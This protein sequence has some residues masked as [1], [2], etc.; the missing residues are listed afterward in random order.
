MAT[1]TLSHHF[2]VAERYQVDPVFQQLIRHAPPFSMGCIRYTQGFVP[3]FRWDHTYFYALKV[4]PIVVDDVYEVVPREMSPSDEGTLA[5]SR[6]PYVKETIVV[7]AVANPICLPAIPELA[8][9]EPFFELDRS[10]IRKEHVVRRYG[11]A[12]RLQYVLLAEVLA[13]SSGDSAASGQSQDSEEQDKSED[14][15]KQFM[16]LYLTR[17]LQEFDCIG[18]LDGKRMI[19]KTRQVTD[20]PRVSHLVHLLNA[21]IGCQTGGAITVA[22]EDGKKS[23]ATRTHFPILCE[24]KRLLHRKS[25]EALAAQVAAELIANA[26]YARAQKSHS[27][28]EVFGILVHHRHAQ[29]VSAA[30]FPGYLEKLDA[31]I[32]LAEGDFLVVKATRPL[33]LGIGVERKEFTKVLWCLLKYIASGRARIGRLD[34][35]TR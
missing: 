12:D 26:Q 27:D 11:L 6:L 17:V 35:L 34:E 13:F 28:P 30:F 21:R 4:C 25:E 15:V 9:F 3:A 2:D 20:H 16:G 18:T 7:N 8:S 23:S 19:L 29:I 22:I 24:Y 10:D 31:S 14:V 32:D 1:S 5:A 33:D